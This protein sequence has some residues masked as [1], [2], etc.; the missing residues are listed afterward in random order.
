MTFKTGSKKARGNGFHIYL[1]PYPI[2]I[3]K[4]V[5][6]ATRLFVSIGRLI[7]SYL[8]SYIIPF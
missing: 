8:L 7:P 5:E 2:L 1:F 6:K 4:M 3:P